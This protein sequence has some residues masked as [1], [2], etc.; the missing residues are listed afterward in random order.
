MAIT[1]NLR[2]K[3]NSKGVPIIHAVFQGGFPGSDYNSFIDLVGRM[4]IELMFIRK[5]IVG[6][7]T[8]NINRKC[9]IRLKTFTNL[10]F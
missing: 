8:T 5:K 10:R 7:K 2:H 9:F 1:K 6:H 4:P 3:V